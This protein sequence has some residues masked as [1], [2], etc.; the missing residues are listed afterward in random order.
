[1]GYKGWSDFRSDT[2]TRPTERMRKAMSDAEVGD[3]LFGEDP[4]VNRLQEKAAEL[5]GKEAAL[6]VPSGTMGN[7]IAMKLVASEGRQV[8]LEEKCHILLYEGGNLARIAAAMAQPLPSLRGEIPLERLREA[9]PSSLKTPLLPVCAVA[10]ETT[11]NYWG[12]HP[13]SQGYIEEVGRFARESRLHLHMDGARLFN[14]AAALGKDPLLYAA[15]CDSLMV[16]LSKGLAAPVGSLLLGNRAFIQEARKVRR[17]LGGGMR[18]VGV[19]A[20][21]GIVALDEM[22]GR[23]VEDHRRARRLAEKVRNLP[24]LRVNPEETETNF[25]M[26]ETPDGGAER[27]VE[28]LSS[29]RVLALPFTSRKVR[30]VTHKDIDD[31]DIQR[32]FE[33]LVDAGREGLFPERST[34]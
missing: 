22:R 6:F 15:P 24:D 2:V 20:A 4:T 10:L 28:F 25:V 21:A 29:K 17:W 26:V 34:L 18:Q 3:D 14:A 27:L 12:G 1:M 7:T 5:L 32:A 13:L 8:L 30:F 23:L 11:H 19:L 16:C 33:A 31:D 9:L